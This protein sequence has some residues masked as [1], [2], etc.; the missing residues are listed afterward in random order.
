MSKPEAASISSND[1]LYREAASVSW[2][3]DKLQID[4][5]AAVSPSAAGAWV[6]AWVW[7]N[8]EEAGVEGEP[9]DHD[10]Q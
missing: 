4:V 9:C 10:P 8:N 1:L 3:N 2:G 5:D 7:V 6:Q